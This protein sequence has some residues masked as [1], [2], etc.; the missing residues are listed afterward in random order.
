M[1]RTR[2][3]SGFWADRESIWRRSARTRGCSW[4]RRAMPSRSSRSEP[5]AVPAS[6]LLVVRY[7]AP[8][9]L[10]SAA[11][12]QGLASQD[13]EGVCSRM[14]QHLRRCEARMSTGASRAD[15]GCARAEQTPRRP[16]SQDVHSCHPLGQLAR[17]SVA[18]ASGLRLCS[19]RPRST[20]ST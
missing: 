3:N 8:A 16:G 9:A 1:I 12:L 7:V 13:F 10:S 19:A 11:C 4:L 6:V 5:S 17:C 14:L 20:L 15:L 18:A 2:W